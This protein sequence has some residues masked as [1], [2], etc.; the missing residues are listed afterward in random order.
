MT[1]TQRQRSP[2]RDAPAPGP[3]PALRGVILVVVG[4]VLGAILLAKGGGVGFDSDRTDVAIGGGS[5]R[6][7]TTTEATTTTVAERPPATVKVVVANGSGKSGL[8]GKTGQFLAT[9]G[10]TTSSATDALQPAAQT[11][12]Y[13]APGF[14]ANARAVAQ[15]LG[16]SADRVQALPGQV[17][18]EQAADT[19]MVVL[20]GQD[21]PAVVAGSTTTTTVAGA[22]TTTARSG[23]G[24]SG[25]GTS[26]TGTS[27]A[28]TTTV[29]AGV[30]TTTA[31]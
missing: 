17:A 18:K 21:V 19:G 15:L 31:R 8:A 7:T 20:L 22:T 1:T 24:T 23:T 26:G 27:G 2:R 30:T 4:V 14:E 3:N 6:S 10:Y 13:F 29:R 5:E 28:T 9:S 12:V 25:T 11:I 16:L